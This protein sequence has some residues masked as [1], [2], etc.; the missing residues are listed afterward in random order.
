MSADIL[1]TS[2]IPGKVRRG[3]RCSIHLSYRRFLERRT[4]LEP[5]TS[6]VL[7]DNPQTSARKTIQLWDQRCVCT[8]ASTPRTSGP[9]KYCLRRST[10]GRTIPIVRLR[11]VYKTV[12]LEPIL[13]ASEALR[14]AL[15]SRRIGTTHTHRFGHTARDTADNACWLV[16][17]NSKQSA[18]KLGSSRGDFRLARAVRPRFFVHLGA[19]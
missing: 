1:L 3:H 17:E 11:L 12:R 13:R 15:R 18:R 4:G 14:A 6:A 16:A 7:G 8:W 9:Y 19:S 2:S 10:S 5:V